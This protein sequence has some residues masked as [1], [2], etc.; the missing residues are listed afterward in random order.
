MISKMCKNKYCS[1]RGFTLIELLVVISII[2]LL[3]SILLPSLTRAKKAAQSVVCGSNMRSMMMAFTIYANN[4]K[5]YLPP[6]F[7]FAG[8]ADPDGEG[9]WGKNALWY[10]CLSPYLTDSKN[11]K[12]SAETVFR[13]PSNNLERQLYGKIQLSGSTYA[14]PVKLSTCTFMGSLDNWR[15]LSS[16]RRPGMTVLVV[17]YYWGCPMIKWW[18]LPFYANRKSYSTRPI[19]HSK[20][21]N[22]LLLDGHVGSFTQ[23]Q[24]INQGYVTNYK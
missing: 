21:D 12:V 24:E 14:M 23:D 7:G 3:L 8:E 16:I 6:G 20:K 4:Y 5:D 2:A 15:K 19:I 1:I 17:D 13:C 18:D 9:A 10:R 22:I 11:M